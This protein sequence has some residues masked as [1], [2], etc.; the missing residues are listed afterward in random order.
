MLSNNEDGYLISSEA[1]SKFLKWFSNSVELSRLFL[2]KTS[3]TWCE[4]SILSIW[5]MTFSI[6]FLLFW[7]F[8]EKRC[9]FPWSLFSFKYYKKFWTFISFSFSSPWVLFANWLEMI[10]CWLSTV[11]WLN[12]SIDGKKELIYYVLSKKKKCFQ[13]LNIVKWIKSTFWKF[14]QLFEKD[15]KTLK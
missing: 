5:M 10:N 8:I 1:V 14:Y 2:C 9:S 11:S 12:S 7:H 13:I 6:L 15:Q 3:V 4:S